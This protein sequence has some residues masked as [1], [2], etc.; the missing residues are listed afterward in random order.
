MYLV[1]VINY[2]ADP[3]KNLDSTMMEMDSPGG[4]QACAILAATV[5]VLLV[6]PFFQRYFVKGIM[7]GSVK[8]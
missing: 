8:E 6:Y 7:I 1:D 4:V 3:L 2:A 5:P